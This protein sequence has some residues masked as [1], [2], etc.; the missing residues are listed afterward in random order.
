MVTPILTSSHKGRGLK[1]GVSWIRNGNEHW[2]THLHLR[3]QEKFKFREFLLPF[4]L[5]SSGFWH[6]VLS[7]RVRILTFRR[8]LLSESSLRLEDG[9]NKS[10]ETF[11]SYSNT[12]RCHN[13]EDLDL[14]L[15]RRENLKTRYRLVKN[16]LFSRL[17]SRN[18]NIEVYESISLCVV[19]CGCQTWSL[20]LTE[21]NMYWLYLRI[22]WI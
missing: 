6:R 8:T 5:R 9:A 3:S 21:E 18:L 11:V 20:T 4:K 10:S 7:R 12:T 2:Y 16:L 17:I 19:L 13:P 22:R 14:N 1:H 15:Q